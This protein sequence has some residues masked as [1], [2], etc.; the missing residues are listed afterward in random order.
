MITT[1]ESGWHNRFAAWVA[2]DPAYQS[3]RLPAT[4]PPATHLRRC[5]LKAG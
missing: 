4:E 2:N 3:S 1:N 5:R